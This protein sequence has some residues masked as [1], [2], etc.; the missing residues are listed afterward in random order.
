MVS[1]REH[2]N[3]ERE[4]HTN[5]NHRNHHVGNH[6]VFFLLVVDPR[7]CER[8]AVS[9][10]DQNDC[11]ALAYLVTLALTIWWGLA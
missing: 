10:Q 3:Q 4:V 11:I 5:G 2:S 9:P 8:I 1:M 6:R 7:H